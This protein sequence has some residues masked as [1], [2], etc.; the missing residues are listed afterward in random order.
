MPHMRH[1]YVGKT[2]RPYQSDD[3][4]KPQPN[5]T[6]QRPEFAGNRI[7]Q[8]FYRPGSPLVASHISS[9]LDRR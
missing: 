9:V 2:F 7:I 5:I 6:R 1:A 8:G 4:V 3:M